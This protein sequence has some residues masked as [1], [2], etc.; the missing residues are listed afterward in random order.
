M[1]VQQRRARILPALWGFNHLHVEQRAKT[2][3]TEKCPHCTPS[4]VLATFEEAFSMPA[5]SRGGFDKEDLHATLA[6]QG[7]APPDERWPGPVTMSLTVAGEKWNRPRRCHRKGSA[8]FD[9]ESAGAIQ[10]ALRELPTA[11]GVG[12]RMRKQASCTEKHLLTRRGISA[13]LSSHMF[14]HSKARGR[15]KGLHVLAP[16][17]WSP[18]WATLRP[19]QSLPYALSLS[20]F[21]FLYSQ[22]FGGTW[23][24][25]NTLE[26][27]LFFFNS[28]NIFLLSNLHTYTVLP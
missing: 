10:E 14:R 7:R 16:R 19:C 6:S 9:E 2:K 21:A 4:K 27:E 12:L 15:L 1:V 28:K 11:M 13:T 23:I 22:P 5:E 8:C 25:V 3:A 20:T 18:P 26:M 17:S 24:S